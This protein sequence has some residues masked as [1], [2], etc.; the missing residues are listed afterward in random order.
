MDGD[1]AGVLIVRLE[2]LA[3]I[4]LKIRFLSKAA[5]KL[6]RP[7]ADLRSILPK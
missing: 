6:V 1:T 2:E 7:R 4:C 5:R 3:K